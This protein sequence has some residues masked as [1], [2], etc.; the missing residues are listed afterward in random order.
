MVAARSAAWEEHACTD[1]IFLITYDQS[2][3]DLEATRLHQSLG[4]PATSFGREEARANEA[5]WAVTLGSL[6][7][8]ASSASS[9]RKL[10]R[11]EDTIT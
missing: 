1:M 8:E 3:L 9:P 5:A 6:C 4:T 10:S 7:A 11:D 2:D